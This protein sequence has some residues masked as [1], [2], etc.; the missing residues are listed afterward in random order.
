MQTEVPRNRIRRINEGSIRRAG[1]YVVYWM[2][3]FRRLDSNYALQYACDLADDLQKPLIILEAL[4]TDYEWACDRFHRFVI[5]GMQDNAQRCASS[6]A[7]YYPY[8]EPR[9]GAGT[10]LVRSLA[11]RAVA[12]ITDDYPCFFHPR[13]LQAT[14]KRL[15]RFSGTPLIAVDSNCL[16]PLSHAERTFT[17]AHSYRRWMQKELPDQLQEAPEQFPL[18]E[19]RAFPE[20][21]DVCAWLTERW[22]P[23]EFEP[24]L[25]DGGLEHFP[26]DHAVA[27]VDERGGHSAAWD[28][29]SEFLSNRL[30]NYDVDRNEP[31][32]RGASELSPYLHFGHISAHEVFWQVMEA[33]SWNPG[34]LNKP[35]GKTNGFWGVGVNAEAFLDQLCTWREIGFNMCWR[36]AEYEQLESLPAWTQETMA[37]HA[38]DPREYI[39]TLEQFES[40]QTHD[41]LWNAAQRQLVTEGRIHN[42]LRM[43]WGKKILHWTESPQRALEIMIELNNKFALDGRDPN[44]YSGIFWVLG[45]YDRAWGPEREI[46]G[47]IRYMT[48]ENTAKKHRV[49]KYLDRFGPSR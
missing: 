1:E 46:F 26:I 21:N 12:V 6:R 47:K 8:V 9:A 27:A 11:E 3:A 16:M 35:N 4:R 31:D 2:T 18:H 41:P 40:A 14:G 5:Q 28:K 45:R 15:D 44:S 17:V 49:A 20:G 25:A 34:R 38:A 43:L 29:L 30:T 13:M 33:E 42:Y 7:V 24:L 23:A 48:S 22:P 39:Y 37:A 10:G 36:E 19:D 32:K